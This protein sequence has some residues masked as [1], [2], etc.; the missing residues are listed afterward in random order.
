M[1]MNLDL[2]KSAECLCL[3]SPCLSSVGNPNYTAVSSEGTIAKPYLI[4]EC[5]CY[6]GED[7]IF[8]KVW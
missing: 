3:P 6:Y 5:R 7:G 1:V 8:R 2:R 4:S